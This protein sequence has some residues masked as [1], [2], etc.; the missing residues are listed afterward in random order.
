M[1]SIEQARLDMIW[2]MLTGELDGA[3]AGFK[4]FSSAHEG[5]AIILEEVEELWAEVM[6]NNLPNARKE[7]LQVAAM[8]VRFLVD[9]VSQEQMDN[10]RCTT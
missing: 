9:I 5:Y 2:G 6:S 8:A 10:R 4:P 1:K 7:A 3:L